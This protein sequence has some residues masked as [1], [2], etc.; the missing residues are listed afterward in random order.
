MK[1]GKSYVFQRSV[2]YLGHQV[3]P[4]KLEVQSKKLDD[5]REAEYL[6]T[7]TQLR[8]YLGLYNVYRIFIKNFSKIA[9]P[10][11]EMLRN[12]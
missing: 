4:G 9:H 12:G 8:N 6:R 11:T 7:Q 5:L 2:T 10:N 1:F 3:S